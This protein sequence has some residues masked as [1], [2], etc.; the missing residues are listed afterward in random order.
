MASGGELFLR[1]WVLPP[2]WRWIGACLLL[3]FASLAL[4]SY[5]WMIDQRGLATVVWLLFGTPS[6]LACLVAARLHAAVY[7]LM[8]P[9]LA[10]TSFYVMGNVGAIYL[11]L[12]GVPTD[13]RV[14]SVS[15]FCGKGS[16]TK[17]FHLVDASGHS[18]GATDDLPDS[19]RVGSLVTV[20]YDP[21]GIV[22]PEPPS[23]VE[24]TGGM[25][26]AAVGLIVLSLAVL[27]LSI[28][29]N[30]VCG[31]VRGPERRH[32]ATNWAILSLRER[33][34]LWHV[35][36]ILTGVLFV[37]AGLVSLFIVI[38][39]STLPGWSFTFLSFLAVAALV[40]LG[41]RSGADPRQHPRRL[42]AVARHLTG[43]R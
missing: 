34:A 19:T 18:I 24:D 28:L 41:H 39:N 33:R 13:A 5:F 3:G 11:S 36:L 21:R 7:V 42:R 12:H 22:G 14:A 16:C 38:P 9:L 29:A 4:S 25:V 10:L 6:A 43:P 8:V 35:L 30:L 17:S 40:W 32:P 26:A 20:V 27:L 2:A 15:L 1:P 31:W 37:I 23:D